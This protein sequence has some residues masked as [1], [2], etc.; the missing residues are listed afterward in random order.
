M[1]GMPP[2]GI[3]R[4]CRGR[5]ACRH[6]RSAQSAPLPRT[7]DVHVVRL[8]AHGGVHHRRAV[9]RERA[10]GAD[11]HARLAGNLVQAGL[12]GPGWV[13][14][15]LGTRQRTRPR[16]TAPLDPWQQQ[17][18]PAP[19]LVLEV[20]QQNGHPAQLLAVLLAQ[21]GAQRLELGL[22][23]PRKRPVH[24]RRQWRRRRGGAR[25]GRCAARGKPSAEQQPALSVPS[26]AA[27]R[28]RPA[29]PHGAPPPACL[30]LVVAGQVLADQAPGEARGPCTSGFCALDRLRPG[31]R[32]ATQPHQ[33]ALCS[34]G[35]PVKQQTYPT[36]P[37]GRA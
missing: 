2:D 8:V 12:Q 31:G 30:A 21:L 35:T 32:S 11:H 23:A 28:S 3:E 14:V 13:G 17:G 24:L 4:A 16:R 36:P 37:R 18:R 6:R 34:R 15:G 33:C 27:P 1:D 5:A 7:R 29:I 9:Q 20:A 10:R 19:H 26:R 25:V 22:A